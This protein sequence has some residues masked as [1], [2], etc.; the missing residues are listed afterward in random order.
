MDMSRNPWWFIF[1]DRHRFLDIS[2]V[3]RKFEPPQI[4]RGIRGGSFAFVFVFLQMIP[5]KFVK[6]YVTEA[7][8]NSRMAVI[9]S[10]LCKFWQIELLNNRSGVFFVGGWSQLMAFHGISEG[11][12]LH[13]RYEGN[14]VF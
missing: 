8:L 10:P 11:E 3:V 13:M 1:C 12:V 5:A 14:M 6:H 9:F 7:Q 4:Y 2:V